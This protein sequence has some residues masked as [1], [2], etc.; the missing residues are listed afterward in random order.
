MDSGFQVHSVLG[1]GL[2]QWKLDSGFQPL[3]GFR[4][5]MP[6]IP[7]SKSKNFP[8]FGFHKEKFRGFRN[9][10]SFSSGEE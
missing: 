4:I 8:N 5:A 6:T 7:E 9:T 1:S 10:D 3:D 2:C